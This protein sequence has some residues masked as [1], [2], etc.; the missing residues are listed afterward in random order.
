MLKGFKYEIFPTEK[1]ILILANYFGLN[2]LVWNAN[3]AL[4]Y[5][6]QEDRHSGKI[7]KNDYYKIINQCYHL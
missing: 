3:L 7:D 5:Q 2:R 1:Q 6:N 4:Y